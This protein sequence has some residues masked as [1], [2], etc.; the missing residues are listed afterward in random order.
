MMKGAYVGGPDAWHLRHDDVLMT[1]STCLSLID[2]EGGPLSG[3]RPITTTM[4]S[5]RD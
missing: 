3:A 5:S 4:T 1:P 2:F